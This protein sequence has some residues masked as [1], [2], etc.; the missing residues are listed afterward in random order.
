MRLV[1]P[2][3]KTLD[4][5]LAKD[6]NNRL[7]AEGLTLSQ[8]NLL[9]AVDEAGGSCTLKELERTMMLSQPTVVGIVQRLEKKG[10]LSSRPDDEDMRAKRVSFT[11]AGSRCCVK[12]HENMQGAEEKILSGMTSDEREEFLRLLAKSIDNMT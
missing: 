2:M 10:L 11:E 5:L 3:I 8:V 6:A 9:V 12:A 1:G 7:R 4:T